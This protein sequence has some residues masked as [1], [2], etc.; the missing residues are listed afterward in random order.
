MTCP[1]CSKPMSSAEK[2]FVC[3]SCREIVIVLKA[4]RRFEPPFPEWRQSAPLLR[5]SA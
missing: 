4:T 5:R 2:M 1:H 3:E